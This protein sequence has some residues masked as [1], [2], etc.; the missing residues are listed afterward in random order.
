MR[1]SDWS[2]DVCSSD[3]LFPEAHEPAALRALA[4]HD[5]RRL[6]RAASQAAGSVAR[7]DAA[8]AS[9]SVFEA[10][11]RR[12]II[13]HQDVLDMRR[14]LLAGRRFEQARRFTVAHPEAGLSALPTFDDPLADKDRK[15]TRLNSSN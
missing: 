2:S 9:L 5:L 7:P 1:I 11:G 15:S 13:D 10:A 8:D 4:D 6:W 12:G 14:I 3:L